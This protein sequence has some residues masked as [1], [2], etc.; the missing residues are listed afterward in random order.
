M[1]VSCGGLLAVHRMVESKISDF[2]FCNGYV[3]LSLIHMTFQH[4]VNSMAE[5]EKL[6]KCAAGV[7]G[8]RTARRSEQHRDFTTLRRQWRAMEVEE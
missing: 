5:K 1:R 4:I 8:D 7:V 3:P 6:R 2:V